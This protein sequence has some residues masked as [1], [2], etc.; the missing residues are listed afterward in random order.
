MG[1]NSSPVRV[2]A[3]SCDFG[4]GGDGLDTF[5]SRFIVTV[6]RAGAWGRRSSLG[7]EGVSLAD[8][9]GGADEGEL[10]SAWAG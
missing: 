10:V 5:C 8:G 9:S 4:G 3:G 7:R 6:G 1:C 2:L